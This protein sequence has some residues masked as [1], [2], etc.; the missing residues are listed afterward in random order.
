MKAGVKKSGYSALEN[1]GDGA[2]LKKPLHKNRAAMG[3]RGGVRLNYFGEPTTRSFTFGNVGPSNSH[4][5]LWGGK[6][7]G[8]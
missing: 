2:T 5:A 6:G 7:E 8:Q 4:L 3:P 1:C